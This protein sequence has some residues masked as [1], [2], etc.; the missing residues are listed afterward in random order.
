MGSVYRMFFVCFVTLTVQT[1]RWDQGVGRMLRRCY[2]DVV[3]VS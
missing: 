2:E 3:M 1:S